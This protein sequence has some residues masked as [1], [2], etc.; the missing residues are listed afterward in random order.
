[1]EI[2]KHWGIEVQTAKQLYSSTWLIND[3]Y[4]LKAHESAFHGRQHMSLTDALVNVGVPVANG[5]KS[6]S[7]EVLVTDSNKTYSLCNYLEGEHISSKEAVS[8][9]QFAYHLGKSLALLHRGLKEIHGQEGYYQQNL[10]TELEGWIKEA[11]DVNQDQDFYTSTIFDSLIESVKAFNN[12]LPR[13]VIHRDFHLGNLI[14][15]GGAIVGYLDF[16]ISQVNIRVFD[17]AYLLVGILAELF[18]RTEYRDKWKTFTQ[19]V[20]RG[21]DD[22]SGLSDQ[23]KQSIYK[24]MIALE[25]L[26]VAYFSSEDKGNNMKLAHAADVVVKWLWESVE[27]SYVENRDIEEMA[28]FFNTRANDYENHMMNHVDG[29]K[30]YYDVTASLIAENQSLNILDLGCGTGLEIDSLF[31]RN[32]SLNII[33]IDMSCEMLGIL[34][35]KHQDKMSQMTLVEANYLS[36]DISEAVYDVAL[37]VQTMHHFE[38]LDKLTLYKKIYR[39]LCEGGYYIET[40]YM[41]PNEAYATECLEQYALIKASKKDQNELFHYD[42]PF[43]VSH[44]ISLLKEAGFI[45]VDKVWQQ[46]NTV[47]LKAYK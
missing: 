14:V 32:D 45:K 20:V 16:D 12:K 13:Q 33:G 7:G 39:S 31:R 4:V 28:S 42:I 38:D 34:K 9:Q 25:S 10:V 46:D 36:Y 35:G 41:A 5:I 15:N 21:Y 3:K 19:V 22:E 23:E 1:M 43:T 11:L 40:D 29:A 8:N 18:E 44:Q 17:I 24:L 30:V 27:I 2:L 26:F 47:I 6:L 37:S